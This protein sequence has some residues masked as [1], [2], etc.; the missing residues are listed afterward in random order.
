MDKVFIISQKAEQQADAIETGIALARVL[1][2]EA[3]VFAY[4]YESFAGKEIG[5]A[6]V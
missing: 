5:R 4:S 3:E 1:E 6:H 2:K